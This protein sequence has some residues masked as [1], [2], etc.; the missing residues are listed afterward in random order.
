MIPALLACAYLA[1]FAL[2]L[3][4]L[5]GRGTKAGVFTGRLAWAGLA[6]AFVLHTASLVE[7]GIRT[8]H[9]PI[10]NAQELL[11][12]VA[13]SLVATYFIVALLFRSSLPAF[14][15]AALAGL[16]C[17]GA[18]YVGSEKMREELPLIVSAHAGLSL[19]AYGAFA[20]VAINS[21]MYLIQLFGIRKRRWA[22]IFALLPSLRE[23]DAVNLR[24]LQVGLGVYT[25]AIG[26]GCWWYLFG[27]GNVSGMKLLFASLV[28]FGYAVVLGLRMLGVLH[29]RRL[30]LAGILLF[31]L[32]LFTLYPVQH[33]G[34]FGANKDAPS[35][36][37]VQP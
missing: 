11:L 9:C 2:W 3:P 23:L 13:W 22:N 19:F 6:T 17:M 32:A 30:A 27:Q 4:R 31:A 5:Y 16:L 8:G 37:E 1:V 34:A 29:G 10:A 7:S 25:A 36:V 15:T 28:L 20:L 18:N 21:A 24:L 14:F 33:S 12:F 26:A 35:A